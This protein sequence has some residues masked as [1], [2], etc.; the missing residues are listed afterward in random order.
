MAR[1]KK[2]TSYSK[3]VSV[4]YNLGDWSNITGEVT[5]EYICMRLCDCHFKKP[6]KRDPDTALIQLKVT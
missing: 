2:D 5:L 3:P 1:P 4:T 6:N